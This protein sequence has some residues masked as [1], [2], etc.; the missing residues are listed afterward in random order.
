MD[1]ELEACPTVTSSLAGAPRYKMRPS[2]DGL[3]QE[4][5][6]LMGLHLCRQ[7]PVGPPVSLL[8]LMV[9]NTRFYDIFGPNNHGFYAD[10]FKERFDWVSVKRRWE[11]MKKIEDKREK[12]VLLNQVLVNTTTK[13][14]NEDLILNPAGSFTRSNSPNG[15]LSDL[16]PVSTSTWRPLTSKDLAVE[17]KRRCTILTKMRRASLSGVIPPSS[18][19]P[20]SPRPGSPRLAPM[21]PTESFKLPIAEPDELTQNLWTCYL[22]LLEN[23]EF[24][25][26]MIFL[27]STDL[28]S[29]QMAIM[30]TT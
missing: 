15:S 27:T 1:Y 28:Y 23:G 14:P 4:L 22:M 17:F 19:R 25:Y 10:L 9:L 30:S 20:N 11:T 12:R 8:P 2:L 21:T 13:I 6:E 3:P 26:S 24:C 5:I 29:M 16:L 7:T 18:S